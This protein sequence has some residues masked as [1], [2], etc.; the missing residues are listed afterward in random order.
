MYLGGA[1]V[2]LSSNLAAIGEVMMNLVYLSFAGDH[3]GNVVASEGRR[4]RFVHLV[5][6]KGDPSFPVLTVSDSELRR[7]RNQQIP[8]KKLGRV[9]RDVEVHLVL[10]VQGKRRDDLALL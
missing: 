6:R 2:L 8:R 9:I 5:H 4:V 1:K 10:D 3:H 7:A